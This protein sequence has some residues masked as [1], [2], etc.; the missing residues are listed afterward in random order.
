MDNFIEI[1]HRIIISSIAILCLSNGIIL[2][3]HSKNN[4]ASRTLAYVIL[5]WGVV[6]AYRM[7]AFYVNIYPESYGIF[8]SNV[9]I[10]GII[11]TFMMVL[12]PMQVLIPGWLNWKRFLLLFTPILVVSGGYLLGMHLLNEETEELHT[13]ADLWASIGHFNV[14]YRFVILICN[15]GYILWVLLWL[16]HYERR[17]VEWKNNNYSDRDDVDISWLHSYNYI[18]ALIF[19]C[20]IAVELIGGKIPV[21]IHSMIVI[22][23]FSYLFYKGLFFKSPY[24]EKT[25]C[26]EETVTIADKENKEP[27]LQ[28]PSAETREVYDTS[29]DSKIPEYMNTFKTWMETEKPFLYKDFKLTDVSR[30]IPLNRSYLSRIFNVGFG[31]NFSEVVRQYRVEYAKNIIQK[32]PSIPSYKLANICG[33]NS[34]TTFT[35]A[36]KAITGMTPTKYKED[37]EESVKAL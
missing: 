34:D 31:S 23:S 3:L 19:T 21:I 30:V 16:Y 9:L 6:Y 18:I 2:L 32:D 24:T 27:L 4:K 29:F 26:T 28:L 37:L 5:L 36:F 20:Y 35:K 1:F 15:M 11:Y 33:F 12:F 10:I 13:Y 25:I 8:R 22:Y 17:Y 7:A 14:W